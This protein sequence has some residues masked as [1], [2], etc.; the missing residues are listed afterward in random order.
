M[1]TEV[2]RGALFAGQMADNLKKLGSSGWGITVAILIEMAKHHG[3]TRERLL[4][5]VGRAWDTWTDQAD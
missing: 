1:A 2:E 4:A 5:V 3:F